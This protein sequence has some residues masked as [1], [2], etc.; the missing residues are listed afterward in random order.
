[1][2][3]ALA[4]GFGS[5]SFPEICVRLVR[6]LPESR[7]SRRLTIE[8]MRRQSYHA[9]SVGEM[10][11]RFTNDGLSQSVE[12]EEAKVEVLHTW[13]FPKFTQR[14]HQMQD[15]HE[16]WAQDPENFELDTYNDPWS[17][18]GLAEI[19][20]L[21]QEKEERLEEAHDEL[22]MLRRETECRDSSLVHTILTRPTVDEISDSSP[23]RRTE[24]I[25]SAEELIS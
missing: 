15:V 3:P 13:H 19:A 7:A 6:K 24:R 12:P 2:A 20:Q 22:R 4:F 16:A 21:K 14:L 9:T 23:S 1:M 10:L 8:K 5:S 11:R 17:E 18:F 25:E